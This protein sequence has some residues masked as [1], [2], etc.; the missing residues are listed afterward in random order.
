MKERDI[1]DLDADGRTILKWYLM[2]CVGVDCMQ[3]VTGLAAGFD[4]SCVPF[5]FLLQIVRRVFATPEI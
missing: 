2:G 1:L 4:L 5:V 3:L